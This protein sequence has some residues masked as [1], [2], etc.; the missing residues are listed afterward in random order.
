MPYGPKEIE[1]KYHRLL[2]A[3]P[4][5]SPDSYRRDSRMEG[6]TIVPVEQ[7]TTRAFHDAEVEKV[8]K[9]AWQMA[10]HEDDIPEIGDSINYDIASLSFLVVRTGADSFKAFY[11]A[12]LHR[13]RKLKECGGKRATELRC[14]F[15]GWA[16]NLDGSL[17]EI[18]SEWDF[19]YLDK[20]K[21]NLP[22][23]KVGKWGRFLFI[24]PDPNC[25]SLES[26]VGDLSRHFTVLPY[27]KRYKEAHVAKIMKANWKV[28]QSAFMEAYHTIL[29]HPQIVTGS[30]QDGNTKYDVFGNYSRAITVAGMEEFGLTNWGPVPA[31]PSQRDVRDGYVYAPRAD[32]NCDVRTPD[33]RTGVFTPNADWV[34][35]ELGESNPHMCNLVSGRQL[36]AGA[37]DVRGRSRVYAST[38]IDP[39]D[40]V[41]QHRAMASMQRE[42]YRSVI[43]DLADQAADIEFAPVYFTLFPNFH[44]WGS[45]NR[46]VYRFRPNGSNPDEAIMECLYM[47]PIPKDGNYPKAVPIHWLGKD[48]D[49]VEAPELG[50]LA[51]VFNQDSRNL[52]FVQEG[53]HAT[54]K[55]NLQLASYNETKLRHFHKLL[56]EWI[57]RP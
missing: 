46:I 45:F 51:K 57:A 34:S 23:V 40:V 37:I 50:M 55:Q 5:R 15:H 43:G 2:D 28:V 32:G 35:G 47:A 44:P 22:E 3:D 41:A 33:G 49:W 17:K 13:G 26:Y 9:R 10:C 53:L 20:A 14:P 39:L 7:F 29:T 18:T 56:E 4:R 16:W 19:K 31:L 27:E 12:C 36:P 38:N 52:P 54:A 11:N 30:S 48:D 21:Q 24:N 6:A 8:W 42:A 25:E 1:E